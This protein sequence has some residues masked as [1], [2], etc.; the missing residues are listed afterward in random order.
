MRWRGSLVIVIILIRMKIERTGLFQYDQ[1]HLEI[2]RREVAQSIKPQI[3]KELDDSVA[4]ALLFSDQVELSP[5]AKELLQKLRNQL[6]KTGKTA[7]YSRSESLKEL[8]YTLKQ[9]A[10]QV[11]AEEEKLEGEKVDLPFYIQIS[12]KEKDPQSRAKGVYRREEELLEKMVVYAPDEQSR[13]TLLRELQ[14]MG[15]KIIQTVKNFGVKI[16]I[17]PAHSALTD[18]KI[19]G[20]A[21]VVK[22]EKTFDGR[23]WET[24]R[25]LY[26]QSRR[27]M[28]IGEERLGSPFSSAAR[29]E[30]AHAY[31]HSFS[32]KNQ[33][34]L[35][36]SVQL[37]NLF[38]KTRKGLV[39]QY[40]GVNP[41]EYFAECMEAFFLPQG[42]EK[43]AQKDPQ[44]YQYLETLFA[45]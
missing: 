31:D 13:R 8:T 18:L 12:R 6:Q 14:V 43:L 1:R 32:V 38:D 10:E 5:Q 9:L 24:V 19:A 40:A 42:K 15:E 39:S 34:R 21:V 44:M 26:D 16:I 7:H 27:L 20:L 41:V 37:W 45:G 25:G 36:L 23:G 35:P 29:H 3:F 22:G 33:R 30:F 2:V 17:L 4:M 28:V 11:H